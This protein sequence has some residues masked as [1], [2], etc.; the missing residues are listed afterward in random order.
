MGTFSLRRGGEYFSM[1]DF[2]WKVGGT[3]PTI[4]IKGEPYQFIGTIY[5][6]T[7]T[8]RQRDILLLSNVNII[9]ALMRVII[10][11]LGLGSHR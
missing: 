11:L 4:V 6:D 9:A 2:S 10:V 7:N 1:Y 3:L 8:Q 5:F